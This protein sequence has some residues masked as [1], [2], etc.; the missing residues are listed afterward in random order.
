MNEETNTHVKGLARSWAEVLLAVAEANAATIRKAG[1][2]DSQVDASAHE[3]VLT[4]ADAL[5]RF[6][7]SKLSRAVVDAD[8]AGK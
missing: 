6:A 1:G 3:L 7:F 8:P 2:T 4:V 5:D